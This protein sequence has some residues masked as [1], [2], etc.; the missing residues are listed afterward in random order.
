MKSSLVLLSA[1]AILMMAG[2]TA[3]RP[4]PSMR[5]I[6]LQNSLEAVEHW[7]VLALETAVEIEAIVELK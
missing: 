7:K 1:L 5:P 4:V 3:N 6:V 2:C